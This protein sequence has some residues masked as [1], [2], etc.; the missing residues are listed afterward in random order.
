[1]SARRFQISL[2]LTGST[3]ITAARPHRSPATL[4]QNGAFVRCGVF[5][6]FNEYRKWPE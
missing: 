3:R 5:V 4:L 1:V 6:I 2:I